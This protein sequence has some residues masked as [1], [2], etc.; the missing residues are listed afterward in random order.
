MSATGDRNGSDATYTMGYT[1]TFLQLLDRR[2]A[3][4]CA[5]YLLPHLRAGMRLLDF[6]CGP[7]SISVGLA[8]A[9]RPGTL[10]GVDIEASQIGIA[11]AAAR[12]GGHTNTAFR[13][14][15]VTALP[16][17]DDYFDAAHGHA[18]LMHVPDTHTALAEVRRVLKPGGWLGC[19][20]LIGQSSFF[21][22]DVDDL[23]GAWTAYAQLLAS[24]G[25]HPQMGRQLKGTFEAAGFAEVRVGAEFEYFDSTADVAFFH[26][27]ATGWFCSGETVEAAVK[28]GV[29]DRSRFDGWR[30]ALDRWKAARGAV[31]A[32]AWGHAVGRKP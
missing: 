23:N 14:G 24:N 27:F 3:S 4:S 26:G 6:G 25:G 31:A 8:E 7:G 32:I 1:E 13:T 28:R 9:V 19:R 21:E 2:S 22:P 30:R 17:E 15:D 10:H 29:A 18:V 16:F 5:A 20:E 12:D 11:E